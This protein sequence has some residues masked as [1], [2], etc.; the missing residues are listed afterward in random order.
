M[1]N[2]PFIDDLA[3]KRMIFHSQVS[4]PEGTFEKKTG[5][6]ETLRCSI[7]PPLLT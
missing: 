6:I 7:D 3:I 4:L 2:G 5:Y 1:K